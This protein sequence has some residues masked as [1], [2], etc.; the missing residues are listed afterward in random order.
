MTSPARSTTTVSPTCTFKRSIS[1][2]LCRVEWLT[3]TPPTGTGSRSA[4]G[5]SVPVRPT[6]TRMFRTRVAACW[7]A[8]LYATAQRGALAV[9][10]SSSHRAISSTL[11]TT[12][13]VWKE[14]FSRFFSQWSQ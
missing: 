6:C 7:A 8:Y 12:P 5:V 13:S 2:M 9:L 14:S 4:T 3:V 11:M 1:S 10:P